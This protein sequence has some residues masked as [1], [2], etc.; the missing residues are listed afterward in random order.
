MPLS[1]ADKNL[2]EALFLKG[3]AKK[4]NETQPKHSKANILAKN[5]ETITSTSGNTEDV[6]SNHLE[7]ITSNEM[8]IIKSYQPR[9]VTV[10]SKAMP[11]FSL[12]SL[13][14]CLLRNGSCT[15]TYLDLLSLERTIKVCE[16]TKIKKMRQEF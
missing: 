13:S 5:I 15:I 8:E 9:N 1:S 2:S 12:F 16:L 4:E 6:T 7:Q 3:N 14:P 11:Q 10:S